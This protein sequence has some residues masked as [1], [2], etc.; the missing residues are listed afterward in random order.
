M[1]LADTQLLPY[2]WPDRLLPE[3]LKVS[4]KIWRWHSDGHAGVFGNTAGRW[5]TNYNKNS[6][7]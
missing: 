4:R 2:G 1:Q 5:I 7:S 6:L 3:R